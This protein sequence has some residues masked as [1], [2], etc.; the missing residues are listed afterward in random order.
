MKRLLAWLWSFFPR[1][2]LR[3]WRYVS[4]RRRGVGVIML[5]VLT[6][7]AAGYWQLTNPRQIRRQA[8][9]YLRELTGG[10][11]RVG[12]ARFGLF[13]GLELKDVELRVPGVESPFFRA[14][15]VALRHRP[16]SLI[17]RGRLDV[18]D[19]QCEGAVIRIARDANTGEVIYPRLAFSNMEGA[20]ARGRNEPRPWWPPLTL[21]GARII[22]QGGAGGGEY[23]TL[24]DISGA[25]R[26]E[27]L[28]HVALMGE[29][30][31]GG[32]SLGGWFWVN[33]NTGEVGGAGAA[34]VEDS[35]FPEF[36]ELSRLGI[37]G[38]VWAQGR[39][40]HHARSGYVEA[41][42]LDC[43][44]RLPPV[45]GGLGLHS[46][47]GL[48]SLDANGLF[49]SGLSGR[50]AEAGDASFHVSGWCASLEPD[51]A[52]DFHIRADGLSLPDRLDGNGPVAAFVRYV[53]ER[54]P[55]K[56]RLNI[57]ADLSRAQGG[58][59]KISGAADGNG[60][61]V[62]D[63]SFPYKV[64]D[65]RVKIAF[66]D[67]HVEF[68]E[69]RGAHGPARIEI[70]GAVRFPPEGK[71][72]DL[73]LTA[74]DVPIDQEIRD[75]LSPVHRKVID[76]L[77]ARGK[78]SARIRSRIDVPGRPEDQEITLLLDGGASMEYEGFPY[79]LESVRGEVQLVDD[80]IEI[81]SASCVSAGMT[82]TM[83]GYVRPR[84]G[85]TGESNLLLTASLPLDSRLAR[86]A[87]EP[88]LAAFKALQPT[89]RA[90][91]TNARVWQQ[92]GGPVQFHV[93]AELEGA[94]VTFN[95]FPYALADVSGRLA[96]EP[97][98]VTILGLSGRHKETPVTL[99]G[100]VLPGE[101]DVGVDL[102]VEANSLRI[103]SELHDALPPSIQRVW[104]DLEPN[105]LADMS[106]HLKWGGLD[107]PNS[108]DYA[109]TIRGRGV[110]LRH[111]AF[112]YALQELSGTVVVTPDRVELRDV[113]SALG[114]MRLAMNGA[115]AT[116]GPSQRV[117][118]AVQAQR[119]LLDAELLAAL[120][121]GKDGIFGRLKP[122]GTCSLNLSRLS[123][124]GAAL[125][126]A[127]APASAS[128][129][130]F[131]ASTSPAAPAGLPAGEL[132]GWLM[133]GEIGLQDAD[134]DLGTPVRLTGS[135]DG[136]IE[137]DGNRLSVDANLHLASM[138]I[139]DRVLTDVRGRLRKDAA[140][141]I[142]RVDD[143][144]GKAYGGRL[145][146]FAEIR[147]GDKPEYGMRFFAENMKLAEVFNAAVADPNQRSA[148]EGLLDATIEV[149]A[150][151]G[152]RPVRHV[153]GLL[154]ISKAKF[155]KVPVLVNRL[156]PLILA[157]PG[158]SYTDGAI[159]YSLQEDKIIFREIHV[160]GAGLSLVGSG[161][162]NLKND[163]LKINFLSRPGIVPRMDNLANELA[164]VV[165][166]ELAEI[167]V[168][169]TL[170]NPRFRT[171]PLR[172][173]DAIVKKLTR[174]EAE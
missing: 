130:A 75:A 125:A 89:G 20:A 31:G 7:G 10:D 103:D 112:P 104:N 118:L 141:D 133:E 132:A 35:N 157:L 136:R 32:R 17:S 99:R 26:G 138:G 67:R 101:D 24:A 66:S 74:S 158:E 159:E 41:N 8:R 86:A 78:I 40:D 21:R 2:R 126:P 151:E 117:D 114:K 3:S 77:N 60:L 64:R 14:S 165:L 63:L 84:V 80:R 97:N 95:R 65:L 113:S 171:I 62:T 134:L 6:L 42:L 72:Y 147:L 15:K 124:K 83:T 108:I 129:P 59:W 34:R 164:G 128:A 155:Q 135:M 111:S 36:A 73:L 109:C 9:D 106:L 56:G 127:T 161:S 22:R 39:W 4:P 85:G 1:H 98:R 170:K 82:G 11:W 107:D 28:Y 55:M 47:R 142:L 120:P 153:S 43:S 122:G 52:M 143:I 88:G 54:Y 167:Q 81:R 50:I 174:P 44:M 12:D 100:V 5:L 121:G 53:R 90:K 110:R 70:S 148:V 154:Q 29:D 18:V 61:E 105:G 13:S 79:P 16:W 123:L 169:G 137:R 49:L 19:V 87:G 168:T 131:A 33:M 152:N 144:V 38:R 23:Q 139:H 48:I 76:S 96:F 119:V 27:D 45:A 37:R 150:A 71:T 163:A 145:A 116:S 140:G 149:R 25:T 93:P 94:T 160:R 172:S 46:I 166:R 57:S 162:M 91:I 68:Q 51:S 69:F 58:A 102:E 92:P 146:G 30:K 156:E 115:F 173:V